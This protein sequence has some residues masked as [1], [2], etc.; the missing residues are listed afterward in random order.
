M[1]QKKIVVAGAILT[2]L[3]IFGAV[4]SSAIKNMIP[5][6]AQNN[7]MKTQGTVGLNYLKAG[8]LMLDMGDFDFDATFKIVDFTL[9]ITIEGYEYEEPWNKNGAVQPAE[10][11][12]K[13]NADQRRL[14]SK[15]KRGDKV[16][17]H[18]IKVL[19]PSGQTRIISPLMLRVS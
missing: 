14:I 2:L 6:L 7:S 3:C 17:I 10:K 18:S 13:F 5:N 16:Y 1:R 11:I 19:D 8:G 9:A 4:Y 15:L 12:A